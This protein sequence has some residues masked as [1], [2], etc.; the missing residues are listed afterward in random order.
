M[1]FEEEYEYD[2]EVSEEMLQREAEWMLKN[3]V[4]SL[5]V[6]SP[7]E[8]DSNKQITFE[9]VNQQLQDEIEAEAMI[10][11]QLEQQTHNEVINWQTFAYLPLAPCLLSSL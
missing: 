9:Q 5:L 6:V 1:E 10:K 4:I 11:H 8:Q 7:I 2:E 3:K